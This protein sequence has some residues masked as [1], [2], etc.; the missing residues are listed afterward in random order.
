MFGLRLKESHGLKGPPILLLWSGKMPRW[1]ER[2]EGTLW[3]PLPRTLTACEHFMLILFV[4][5]GS[6]VSESLPWIPDLQQP[7]AFPVIYV[8][9]AFIINIKAFLASA[10]TQVGSASSLLCASLVLTMQINSQCRMD[11]LFPHCPLGNPP[12]EISPLHGEGNGGEREQELTGFTQNA[13]ACGCPGSTRY[14]FICKITENVL[15]IGLI[16]GM[17]H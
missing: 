6:L 14:L 16:Q 5:T 10:D 3:L 8:R 15:Q 1:E 12:R 13:K 2:E 7:P 4:L 9:T 17:G 11:Q